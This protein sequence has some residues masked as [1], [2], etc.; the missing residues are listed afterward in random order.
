MEKWNND[1]VSVIIPVYNSAQYIKRTLDSVFAQ[2]YHNIEIIVIDDCS[3]DSSGE[4]IQAV[5]KENK[6][7]IYH[8]QEKNSGAAVA[9]NSGMKL[10]KGRYIAFLDSD[11]IWE[12]DKIEKQLTFMKKRK[13][14]FVYCAYDV[15]NEEGKGINRKVQIKKHVK[16][17]DLLT[18]T[19]IATPTV[20]LDRNIT[21]EKFMPLRRTGQDYAYWLLLLREFDAYGIDEV[22]VHV[23]KRTGSLS[24]NKFQNI[25]DVWEVQTREEKINRF[26]SFFN[27][28]RYCFY[29]LC[30]Y[31]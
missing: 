23:C 21:D 8:L 9:R 26:S 16:Y 30:K 28:V 31:L 14:A 2:T 27:V 19:M 6:N 12:P 5:A 1:M 11:D 29:M 13:C 22:L 7:V 20:L 25:R 17:H 4:M 10:A 24:K 15:I 18:K 3:T